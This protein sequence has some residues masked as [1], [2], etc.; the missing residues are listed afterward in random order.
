MRV[1]VREAPS[2]VFAC[3]RPRILHGLPSQSS[4]EG[5]EPTRRDRTP[6][7]RPSKRPHPPDAQQ[8]TG[9]RCKH[10]MKKCGPACS[11]QGGW[12][13]ILAG[14]PARSA[15]RASDHTAE[16]SCVII[17]WNS[18]CHTSHQGSSKSQIGATGG[19]WAA[20]P[21]CSSQAPVAG[22]AQHVQHVP[23]SNLLLQPP[24]RRR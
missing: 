15:P 8:V 22:V 14:R 3:S 7:T 5:G 1:G 9:T 23:R 19:R 12:S 17:K 16:Q 10:V 24:R 11:V 6:T 21:R 2:R 13:R 4:I 20:D 18:Q